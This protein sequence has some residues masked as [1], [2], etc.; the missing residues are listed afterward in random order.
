MVLDVV[1][2]A[3]S[4]PYYGEFSICRLASHSNLTSVEVPSNLRLGSD[5]VRYVRLKLEHFDSGKQSGHP[6]E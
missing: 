1:R 6:K 2:S 5:I 4:A 3:G